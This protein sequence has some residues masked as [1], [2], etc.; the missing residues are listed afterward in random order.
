MLDLHEIVV[1][2]VFLSEKQKF[3]KLM[4]THHYLGALPKIRETLW[5]VTIWQDKKEPDFIDK[6]SGEH[7][8]I[9]AWKI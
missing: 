2:P 9:E 6:S 5:Y 4:A 3:Q 1:R 8:R 7:G